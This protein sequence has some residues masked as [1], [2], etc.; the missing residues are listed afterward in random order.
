MTD[1]RRRIPRTDHLLAAPSIAA[2]ATRLGER[3]VRA[4]VAAAQEAARRGEL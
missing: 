3:R 1:P 2:A 4:A